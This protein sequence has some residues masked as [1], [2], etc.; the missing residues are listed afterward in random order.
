MPLLTLSPCV[1]CHGGCESSSGLE[2][3]IKFH[4][5]RGGR[6]ALG[7]GISNF[8]QGIRE[9]LCKCRTVQPGRVDELKDKNVNISKNTWYNQEWKG[10]NKTSCIFTFSPGE[11]EGSKERATEEWIRKSRVVDDPM[12]AR[13]TAGLGRSNQFKINWVRNSNVIPSL[14]SLRCKVCQGGERETRVRGED[15]EQQ[16]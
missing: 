13:N 3:Q 9:K 7:S 6:I 14:P 4:K 15:R 12:L 1:R 16:L 8:D 2:I 11:G 10:G 5:R